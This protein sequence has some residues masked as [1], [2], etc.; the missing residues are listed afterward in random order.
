MENP[1]MC[2]TPSPS[3]E[4]KGVTTSLRIQKRPFLNS[5]NIADERCLLD[6]NQSSECQDDIDREDGINIVRPRFMSPCLIPV[7]FNM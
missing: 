5:R 4:G 6:H 2:S 3:E 1:V 7:K